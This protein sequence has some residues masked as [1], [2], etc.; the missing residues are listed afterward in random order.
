MKT[1]T[2]QKPLSTSA[3]ARAAGLPEQTVR[4]LE[5]RGVVTAARDHNNRR[6]F[7]LADVETLRTYRTVRSLPHR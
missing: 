5:K 2:A 1:R 7:T 3:A 6:Q 4:I